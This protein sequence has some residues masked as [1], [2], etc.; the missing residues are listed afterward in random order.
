VSTNPEQTQ[1][2]PVP[3]ALEAGDPQRTTAHSTD[4]SQRTTDHSTV[5]PLATG[6][7]VS[8]APATDGPTIPGYEIEGVLGRG[9]MGIVYRA[10]H[11]VLKRAVAL[12][13]IL[14]GGQAGEAE[15]GRFRSEVEAVA[16]FQHPNIVQ[17]FEVGEADGL[18]F[19][20][21][22]LV[23][24]GSLAARLKEG[25]L[26]PLEA[27][28]VVGL[29]AGA[30]DVAHGR[31]VI[32]RDLKP[33]NVL[34]T[35]DGTPKV[36]DFGLAKQLDAD[37]GQTQA[38]VVM[39]TPSYMAPEQARGDVA[40]VNAAADI[41][42]LGAILY[43]CLTGRPPFRAAT[44]LETLRQVIGT[45]PVAPRQLNP[46]CPR[47]LEVIA[48]K[49]LAKDPARRYGSA[50]ELEEDLARW[51]DHKPIRARPAGLG[52]QLVKW[53]RRRPAVAASLGVA[54]VV[55]T[56]ALVGISLALA[57]AIRA[58]GVKDAALLEKEVAL[59]KER[60]A[61]QDKEAALQEAQTTTNNYRY[62]LA[63]AAWEKQDRATALE[64]LQ[65]VDPGHRG[66]G[67][68]FMR[69]Q[70]RGGLF[71]LLG[72]GFGVS[73]VGWTPDGK[74]IATGSRDGTVRL[75]D[76][77][78]GE[79]RVLVPIGVAVDSLAIGPDGRLA[80][81]AERSV[82]VLNPSDG[83]TLC[84]IELP[85]REVLGFHPY[86]VAWDPRGRRV[87]VATSLSE[88][89]VYDAATGAQVFEVAEAPEAGPGALAW[90][91]DGR[92]LC[93]GTG[94]WEVVVCDGD[95][96]K[97]LMRDKRHG[98]P[99]RALAF[100]PDGRTLASAG[101]DGRVLLWDRP[102]A[103]PPELRFRA[104]IS[105]RP[106]R[107][108]TALAWL[109]SGRE[110]A[111][112][113][114]DGRIE[115]LDPA[116]G[117][118]QRTYLGHDGGIKALA[119]N[120]DGR[121][122]VSGSDDRRATVWSSAEGT[123]VLE[124]GAFASPSGA[125]SP[126][127]V[128]AA[129]VVNGQV[130]RYALPSGRPLG[131]MSGAGYVSAVTYRC[132][133][134]VLAVAYQSGA[135]DLFELATGTVARR[136]SSPKGW[137]TDLAFTAGGQLLTL[138]HGDAPHRPAELIRW[139]TG[140]GERLPEPAVP[141][142]GN[143]PQ[144]LFATPDGTRVAVLRGRSVL[145]WRDPTTGAALPEALELPGQLMGL[146]WHPDGVGFAVVTEVVRDQYELQVRTVPGGERTV[147]NTGGLNPFGATFDAT[148]GALIWLGR[149]RNPD[150]REQQ[151]SLHV[152]DLRTRQERGTVTA[153]LAGLPLGQPTFQLHAGPD[154]RSLVLAS[155]SGVMRVLDATP[156]G[157][158]ALS[159][160]HTS[161]PQLVALSNGLNLVAASDHEVVLWRASDRSGHRL[162][163]GTDEVGAVGVG[164]GEK[165]MAAQVGKR[166]VVWDVAA[167]REV[168]TLTL[169]ESR[170]KRYFYA[171][172][173]DETAGT[174]TL[175]AAGRGLVLELASG[176]TLSNEPKQPERWPSATS[177]DGRWVVRTDGRVVSIESPVPAQEERARRSR[178]LAPDPRWHASRAREAERAD[179][180][181]AAAFH[182]SRAQSSGDWDPTIGLREADAWREAGRPV[183]AAHAYLRT[184]LV[185]P[186]PTWPIP[187]GTSVSGLI[188]L[189]D[190]PRLARTYHYIVRA[191]P[192]DRTVFT[193]ALA[194][195]VGAGSLE[196][197]RSY[198]R[199]VLDQLERQPLP[200][201]GPDLL[202]AVVAVPLDAEEAKRVVALAEKQVGVKKDAARLLSLAAALIR[203]DRDADAAKAFATARPLIAKTDAAGEVRARVLEALLA[204]RGAA[205]KLPDLKELRAT[206]DR[207]DKRDTWSAFLLLKQMLGEIERAD[208]PK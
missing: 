170:T 186:E 125:V 14:A 117:R 6:P 41:Y 66:W 138:A 134:R 62:A 196:D 154:D 98:N 25:P 79:E 99:L 107:T 124:L 118:V 172:E 44:V 203:A 5:D 113:Y 162:Y 137:V 132:D 92:L 15:R 94:G 155:T 3:P 32:H 21:L 67:W 88:L 178:A 76:G 166:V 121:W 90:S 200:A 122:L 2:L 55:I 38:G 78:T 70:Y 61:L 102:G 75:W 163:T 115:I 65:E 45:D 167:L 193:P 119:Y 9:G 147:V 96:G 103:G 106:K 54:A 20:A 86:T 105:E 164:R 195:F 83:R 33:A 104:Q 161:T 72:H 174:V 153:G 171:L 17:V 197:F 39:G 148:G 57:E 64:R 81:V 181:F 160:L 42:A 52:E 143:E 50:R 141:A 58:N 84:R 144:R 208:P 206:I 133:G 146:A 111:A 112:G 126:G 109:P 168:R 27:A 46:A 108:V 182:W 142:R 93:V 82:W 185:T 145:E 152:L 26:P 123:P 179:Q 16:R 4:D 53:C 177:P 129:V 201:T 127:G 60:N 71:A 189:R 110:L 59:K 63:Q 97:I 23:D 116:T 73:G 101:M 130:E 157:A 22:E 37:S 180:W 198:R 139:D 8:A 204:A 128:E 35:S 48:L 149:S 34:L 30:M 136:L 89:R 199:L 120:P 173:L 11:L 77:A 184:L 190:W 183:E 12:K 69:R 192:A 80:L 31:N 169:P 191:R 95:M 85:T 7:L 158:V 24:G 56:V 165:L 43:E 150:A 159:E 194:A 47:D 40:N 18:P 13:M 140:T 175:Y 91:P 202:E 188:I 151:Y 74:T 207:L 51:R 131:R 28:R 176:K 114:D 1:D 156:A 205:E 36:T 135:I 10:R 187:D 49:C 19:C 68:E 87:A 100:S 29:L